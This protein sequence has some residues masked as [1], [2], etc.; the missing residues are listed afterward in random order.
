MVRTGECPTIATCDQTLFKRV[1]CGGAGVGDGGGGGCIFF[2]MVFLSLC[3]G[4][5]AYVLFLCSCF[6][7]FVVAPGKKTTLKACHKFL[8][9]LFFKI[10]LDF[11]GF[12]QK[13]R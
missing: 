11:R 12:V 4:C 5:G 7:L 3:F 9:R 8:R 6:R 13:A 1:V 10:V 2:V